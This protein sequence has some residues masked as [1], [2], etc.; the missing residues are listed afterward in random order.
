MNEAIEEGVQPIEERRLDL[1]HELG[2]DFLFY[3]S[4]VSTASRQKGSGREQLTLSCRPLLVNVTPAALA[5]AAFARSSDPP[6]MR[7]ALT[8][9]KRWNA[10]IWRR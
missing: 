9:Q 5:K 4:G 6:A 1:S 10:A 7:Y 2:R 8:A 3:R